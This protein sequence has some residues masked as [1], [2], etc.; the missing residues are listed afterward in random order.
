MAK[1]VNK[2]QKTKYDS[3]EMALLSR[4]QPLAELSPNPCN[5]A[6]SI[7]A[8]NNP[9]WENA[10][11]DFT[12]RH[13][14]PG[15]TYGSGNYGCPEYYHSLPISRD[16]RSRPFFA[17]ANSK[18]TPPPHSFSPKSSTASVE[19]YTETMRS[20]REQNLQAFVD[21]HTASIYC[22]SMITE[23]AW[24]FNDDDGEGDDNSENNEDHDNNHGS[25]TNGDNH[26]DTEDHGND[27][28][29]GKDS[30]QGSTVV[31]HNNKI[32][33]KK[34]QPFP[35]RVKTRFT[36][37]INALKAELEDKWERVQSLF[38]PTTD[39]VQS[40]MK[41]EFKR[42]ET[43]HAARRKQ[44]AFWAEGVN[45]RLKLRRQTLAI[46]VRLYLR[47]IFA[48]S[49]PVLL[50]ALA[51]LVLVTMISQVVPWLFPGW[52]DDDDEDMFNGEIAYYL[53]DEFGRWSVAS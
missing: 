11:M 43:V 39:T 19:G 47:L 22:S 2:K 31:A 9:I 48:R 8:Y 36:T 21:T 44:L 24:S 50:K 41:A 23:D 38:I 51:A 4:Q 34:Q 49:K 17:F 42:V 52:F 33:E 7:K 1:H 35:K 46:Y 28:N 12:N 20:E 16:P 14:V 3:Y 15:P 53:V 6:P 26:G 32:P 25:A 18:P 45:Y 30:P 29:S 27:N 13:P 37:K 10:R 40:A 5:H